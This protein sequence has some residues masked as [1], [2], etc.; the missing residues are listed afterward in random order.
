M[1]GLMNLLNQ[2]KFKRSL[3]LGGTG[4]PTEEDD[5][6]LPN[7]AQSLELPPNDPP[8]M[9]V[10][11][12]D[13]TENLYG[14]PRSLEAYRQHALNTPT[15]E[16]SQPDKLGRGLA[17][18]SGFL[19]QDQNPNINQTDAMNKLLDRPYEDARKDYTIKREG[20]QGAVGAEESSLNRKRLGSQR[21]ED[22]EYRKETSKQASEDRKAA[23][24]QKRIDAEER[25]KDRDLDRE[26]RSEASREAAQA[27]KE[28]A[29]MNNDLR[30]DIASSKNSGNVDSDKGWTIKEDSEG[31]YQRINSRTGEVQKVEG[32][33]A[34]TTP[35]ENTRRGNLQSM[36]DD[37]SRIERTSAEKSS[38]I[39]PLDSVWEGIKSA[40]T[41]TNPEMRDIKRTTENLSDMLLRARSGAQINEKE[42]SRLR[43]LVP[44]T[45][46]PFATFQQDLKLFKKELEATIKNTIPGNKNKLTIEGYEVEEE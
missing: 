36:L 26:A 13:D 35:G 21:S 7:Q 28:I 22:L 38:Q 11:E 30:R 34:K 5:F 10:P 44:N 32:A 19:Q 41:G 33:R 25:A 3:G 45:S 46:S 40:T 9:P 12:I 17:A 14:D 24:E 20:L 31:G 42:F 39:G 2:L 37:V 1:G 43:Q 27:R 16:N 23:L 4:L 6:R 15:R 8:L 29:Q 18:L